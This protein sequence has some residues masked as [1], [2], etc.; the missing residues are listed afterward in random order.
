MR[1]DLSRTRE[2]A[3]RPRTLACRAGSRWA[4]LYVLALDLLLFAVQSLTR[5]R[6]FTLSA[7]LGGLGNF[8][9]RCGDRFARDRRIS[10]AAL[11]TVMAA[12]QPPDRHLRFHWR[13][14]G[15]SAAGHFPDHALSSCRTIR[16]LCHHV[17][18]RHALAEHGSIQPR[19]CP[20]S[21][22]PACEGEK[23]DAAILDR[24]RPRRQEWSGVKSAPGSTTGGSPFCSG[25]EARALS[26]SILLLTATL[27]TLCATTAALPSDRHGGRR[28]IGIII[29]IVILAVIL[30]VFV[31]T[32]ASDLQ[33][34]ARQGPGARDGRRSRRNHSLCSGK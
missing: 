8:S 10:L 2:Q 17:R 9:Q 4:A 28:R 25:P 18:H 19:H 31:F 11:T 30:V 13:D 5:A 7:S 24:T 15:F 32:F 33:R 20:A 29:L 14:S 23:L 6:P 27:A 26:I 21:C 3:A 12:A 22:H 1:L 16:Q 34:A